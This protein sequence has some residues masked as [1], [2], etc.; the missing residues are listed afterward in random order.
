[1]GINKI[2]NPEPIDRNSSKKNKKLSVGKA[3]VRA[4]KALDRLQELQVDPVIK[5][6]KRI[7]VAYNKAKLHPPINWETHPNRTAFEDLMKTGFT[8][9]TKLDTVIGWCYLKN[10]NTGEQRA[11]ML[12][13]PA[14]LYKAQPSEENPAEQDAFKPVDA[15]QDPS[16]EGFILLWDGKF[17]ELLQDTVALT[18]VGFELKKEGAIRFKRDPS[19]SLLTHQMEAQQEFAER[20]GVPADRMD[21]FN[22]RF[23]RKIL[24]TKI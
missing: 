1:M 3:F 7:E 13:V 22:H 14:G 4:S 6:K 10:P 17:E 19:R 24:G 16:F 18:E 8:V 9:F 5:I 11:F 2:P 21:E 20:I 23:E 15:A 12:V